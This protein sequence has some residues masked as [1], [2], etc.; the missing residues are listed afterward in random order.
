MWTDAVSLGVQSG[1]LASLSFRQI[2]TRKPHAPSAVASPTTAAASAAGVTATTGAGPEASTVAQAGGG[3]TTTAT[4]PEQ[5][6]QPHSG[7]YQLSV[8]GS[9]H[10]KFGPFSACTHTFPTATTLVVQPAAGEASGAYDFDQRFY[11]ASANQHDE[12]HIYSYSSNAVTL[13]YEEATVTCSGVK[14][15]TTV[16]Y[17]PG[18]IRVKLPLTVGATWHSRG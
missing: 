12:R 2:A 5:L 18:Q 11:P 15:S 10:V 1:R 9:E 4:R 6:L 17:A 14:Q 3:Q 8:S 13:T 7:T 16:N